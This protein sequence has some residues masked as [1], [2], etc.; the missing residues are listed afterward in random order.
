MGTGAL[1]KTEAL[2][3]QRRKAEDHQFYS[4]H[5]TLE[6]KEQSGVGCHRDTQDD[7]FVKL[8]PG[9]LGMKPT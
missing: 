9:L 2:I 6:L 8:H 7:M 5:L 1:R 4:S 3:Y